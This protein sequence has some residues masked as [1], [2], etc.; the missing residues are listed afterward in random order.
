MEMNK[1]KDYQMVMLKSVFLI[2]Q[3][4]ETAKIN[5]NDAEDGMRLVGAFISSYKVLTAIRYITTAANI[6]FYVSVL[7]GAKTRTSAKILVFEI[8]W[9]GVEAVHQL[10]FIK[11]IHYYFAHEEIMVKT[12]LNLFCIFGLTVLYLV[13]LGIDWQVNRKKIEFQLH[14]SR[15]A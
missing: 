1:I 3:I 10:V 8:I 14:L 6:M 15:L 13:Y 9:L 4:F 2:L 7:C 12:V 5:T 11:H